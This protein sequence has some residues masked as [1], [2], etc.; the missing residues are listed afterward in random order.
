MKNPL[1]IDGLK[2]DLRIYVL[3]SGC[4]PLRLYIYQQGL[5]RLA[6]RAYQAPNAQ[7][8][9]E[10]YIHLTNYSLNKTNPDY[11]YNKSDK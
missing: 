4:E 11:V 7:N 2:F 5:V 10:N 1:L 8:L 3:L 6:T 9:H